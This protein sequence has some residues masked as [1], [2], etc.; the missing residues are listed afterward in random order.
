VDY[1]EATVGDTVFMRYLSAP[2]IVL[3]VVT[4]GNGPLGYVVD[5]EE[6]GTGVFRTDEVEE[7]DP[8]KWN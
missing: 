5:V 2:G 3:Q 8:E 7:F 1:D 4:V 6:Y